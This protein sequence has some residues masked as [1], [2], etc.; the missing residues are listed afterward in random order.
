[1]LKLLI[2]LDSVSWDVR[3]SVHFPVNW[4]KWHFDA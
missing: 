1:M 3:W 4:T 2:Y